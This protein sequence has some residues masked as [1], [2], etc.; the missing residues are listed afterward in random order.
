MLSIEDLR[1]SYGPTEVL[2]GVSL[3]VPEGGIV[4]LLGGNGS[5]KSTALNTVSGFLKPQGGKVVFAGSR[6]DGL[7]TD[8]IVKAGIVQVPQGREVFAGLTVHENLELGAVVRRDA[9]GVRADLKQVYARF[10]RLRERRNQ[11]AGTRSGGGEQIRAIPRALMARPRRMLMDEPSAGLSPVMVQE[12]SRIIGELHRDG[13]TILLVEQNVGIAL[14]LASVAHILRDGVIAVTGEAR[15]L[16]DNPDV[17][18]SYL[19]G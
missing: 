13:M 14:A 16:V 10:P 15:D 11:R 7:P 4:A 8:R 2:R 1:V 18:R 19:G 12:I 3:S 5:G 17:V 6:I 9:A